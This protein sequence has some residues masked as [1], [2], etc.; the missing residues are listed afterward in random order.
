MSTEFESGEIILDGLNI[1]WKQFMM[2]RADPDDNNTTYHTN[3]WVLEHRGKRSWDERRSY[4]YGSSR[5]T[6]KLFT[7]KIAEMTGRRPVG[8][9]MRDYESISSLLEPKRALCK[10]RL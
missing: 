7:F 8:I 5:R 10:L 1:L 9:M 3:V 2:T 4:R 6:T